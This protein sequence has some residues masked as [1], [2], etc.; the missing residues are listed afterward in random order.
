MHSSIVEFIPVVQSFKIPQIVF[1]A[2]NSSIR[3]FDFRMITFPLKFM[4]DIW[5]W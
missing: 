1:V 3:A 5:M 2:L 4:K